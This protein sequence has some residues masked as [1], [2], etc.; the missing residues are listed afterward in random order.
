MGPRCLFGR[1]WVQGRER[2]S[3][4]LILR[5]LDF[6][7][8]DPFRRR[9]LQSSQRQLYRSGVF[10]SVALS[11]PDSVAEASPVDI[12]VSVSERLPRRLKLGLGYDTEEQVR[13]SLAWL[14]RNLWGGGTQVSAESAASAL[15]TRG[16]VSVAHPY[17][18]GSKTWLKLTGFVEHQRPVEVRVKRAGGSASLERTFRA[19]GRLVF[20]VRTE[21]IDFKADSARTTFLVEYQGDTRDD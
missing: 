16:T 3:E 13:G 1:V 5:G 7:E 2:A 18:L 6:G 21:L 11:L 15:E 9:K 10:R 19:A 4:G 12:V 17:I 20:Q 14:H 8:G